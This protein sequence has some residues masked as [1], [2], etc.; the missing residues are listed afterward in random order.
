M[1]KK[2]VDLFI[3]F[4][5]K[6][7]YP[8]PFS[9]LNQLCDSDTTF[10]KLYD[11]RSVDERDLYYFGNREKLFKKFQIEI[12]ERW[13]ISVNGRVLPVSVVSMHLVGGERIIVEAYGEPYHN[14]Q[15]YSIH[16]EFIW[17]IESCKDPY[18]EDNTYSFGEPCGIKKNNEGRDLLLISYWPVLFATDLV[19]G[20]GTY[21]C[22]IDDDTNM[23]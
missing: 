1:F 11:S 21:I 17:A 8:S 2:L 4:T 22:Q 7:K 15:A 19:T 16:G 23:K 12:I 6:R 3:L 13:K 9:D 10:E 18:R 5:S 20:K 14:I